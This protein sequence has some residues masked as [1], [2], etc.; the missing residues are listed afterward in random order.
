M[1]GEAVRAASAQALYNAGIGFF[2]IRGNHDDSRARPGGS[3]MSIP[4]RRTA[5]NNT[6]PADV[7]T[8]PNPEPSTFVMPTQQ[9]APFTVGLQLFRSQRKPWP[10][11]LSYAFN[12]NNATFVLIDQF[13]PLNG[14]GTSNPGGGYQIDDQQTWI[15]G[16]LASRPASTHA[17]VFSHKGLITEDHVDNLFGS[18]PS[19]GS[20][21][22]ERLHHG[23]R[24]Q[25]RTLLHQRPRSHA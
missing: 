21:R 3:S 16:V 4:R 13:T 6:T 9:G 7:Y 2:P 14:A 10:E 19:Q 1:A 25:R 15:S 11:G 5:L 23:P 18:D 8:V 24:H 12:A 22:N 17:F 20:Y